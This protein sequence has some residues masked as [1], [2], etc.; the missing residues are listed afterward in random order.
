MLIKRTLAGCLLA[1]PMLMCG[2]EIARMSIRVDS[3]NFAA[4]L[5]AIDADRS[6]WEAF[7]WLTLALMLTW[8]GATLGLVEALRASRPVAAWVGGVIGV[9]GAVAFAMHQGQYV[10]INAVLARDPGFRDTA[11]RVGIT[12]TRMEDA[13]V[14][15][16]L[17]GIWLGPVVLTAA[18]ARAGL[19]SWWRFACVPVW[20]VLFVFV[21]SMS[22]VFALVH[23]ILVPPFLA[24]ALQLTRSDAAVDEPTP[25]DLR[26]QVL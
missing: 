15:L 8:L 26:P 19:L 17:L 9:T 14:V 2:A 12:G 20:V 23:L 18:M 22:P 24:V 5:A 7:G 13:T 3:D 16:Q 25:A 4:K 11:E 1:A 6:L 10:E 21:G